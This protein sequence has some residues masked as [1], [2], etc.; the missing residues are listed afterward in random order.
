MNTSSIQK[1]SDSVHFEVLPRDLSAYRKGNVGVDYVHRF[2]SG[3]PGPHVLVNA[4]THGN[5]FCGMVAAT[6]L[7]DTGVRPLVG[8]LT[9]S[10]A[11]V[12]A[13][14]T[15]D[16][17]R[18]FDSR[19]IDHNFNRIW[20]TEWLDGPETSVE[21]LRARAMRQVVEQ[22]DHLLDIHSTSQDVSPFWVYLGLARHAGVATAVGMPEIHLVMP[23]GLGSGV[24]VIQYGAFSESTSHKTALV[25][26][27]GQHFLKSSADTALATTLGFLAHW[28]MI[29]P[30]MHRLPTPEQAQRRYE[31][32]ETVLVQT[33]EFA[34][35]RP[36]IGFERFAAGERIATDGPAEIRALCDDCVVFMPTRQPVVGREGMYLTRPLE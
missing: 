18:P 33:P 10:F 14:E 25:V 4:L 12:A 8:T 27:C 15:F 6:H 28:G 24:P 35:T 32:L 7:L 5:E 11:N 21:L 20:S 3:R 9:I 34:F 31:L 19:Q 2:E 13:Y 30:A 16:M 23:S 22:A 17:D 26:E 36:L 1:P 29:D